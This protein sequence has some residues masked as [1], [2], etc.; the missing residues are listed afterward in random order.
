[1][2]ASGLT[3]DAATLDAYLADPQKKVP[4]NKMPFPGLKTENERSSLIAYLVAASSPAA[5]A[6]AQQA[7]AASPSRGPVT[8]GGHAV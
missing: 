8:T 6:V 1:M 3:W 7:P 2:K 4:G 5:P